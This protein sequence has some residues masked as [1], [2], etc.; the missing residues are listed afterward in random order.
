MIEAICDVALNDPGGS[1]PGV[2]DFSQRGVTSSLWS[3][4]MR[5]LAK[6]PIKI[7]VQD[8]PDDLSQEFVAPD[9]HI[10]STLPPLPSQL[11]NG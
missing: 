6:C 11:W 3:E 5:M 1:F 8:Q 7:G 4:T 10:H 2:V 9:R